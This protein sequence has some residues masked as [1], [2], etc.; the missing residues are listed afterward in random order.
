LVSSRPS[1]VAPSGLPREKSH[2]RSLKISHRR[3]NRQCGSLVIN[4]TL[5]DNAIDEPRLVS[6]VNFSI[7]QGC[8]F[9]HTAADE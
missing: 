7:A 5:L 8:R 6:I 3:T 2:V 1:C 9:F 4:V